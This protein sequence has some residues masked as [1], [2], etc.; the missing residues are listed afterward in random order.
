[1]RTTTT[2][3]MLFSA[4]PVLLSMA[5]FPACAHGE[6][7][8]IVAD[9]E[10][11]GGHLVEITRAAFNK[12]GHDTTFHFVPWARA[13]AGAI[14]GR[15]DVLMAAYYSEERARKLAYSEPIG[16]V[17]VYFWKKKDRDISYRTFADMTPYVIGVIRASTVSAEF[18]Q[19]LPT[20]KIDEVSSAE[21]NI[22]KLL[23]GRI[24]VFVEKKQR[25]DFL[26]KTVF[27]EHQGDIVTLGEPLKVGQFFNAFSME[28]PRHG[29]LLRDFNRGLK[30]IKEDGTEEGILK[31]HEIS[32]A[33]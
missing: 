1:M 33:P 32:G 27:F 28:H 24:D 5:M 30:M 23:L 15:Y 18:D 9:E 26:L 4:I 6:T 20:L 29:Q 10:K 13:L 11:R 19:A 25:V 8:S 31:K 21:A 14:S 2:L 12:A 3:R 22:R 7:V 16:S 17:E